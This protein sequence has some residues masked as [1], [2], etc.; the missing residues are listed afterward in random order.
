MM[1]QL[2]R[3]TTLPNIGKVGAQKLVQ[4]GITTPEELVETGSEQAFIRIQTIDPG[5]CL[6]MLQALEGAVQGVS[7]HDLPKE[8]KESLKEFYHLR[9]I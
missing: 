8:R 2:K 1:D 4:A 6:C 7:W 5:A 9:R 3:L